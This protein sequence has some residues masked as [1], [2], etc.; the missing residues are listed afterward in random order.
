VFPNAEVNKALVNAL[1]TMMFIYSAMKI[2]AK[3]PPPYSTLKPETSSD[4][5][6][7]KSKGVR[8]VSA[9][10]EVN[11]QVKRGGTSRA[12][13]LNR[14]KIGEVKLYLM[15]RSKEANIRSA[16]LISYE[17]VCAIARIVPINAYFLL[18]VHPA[19]SRT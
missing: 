13:Q 11:Q 8:F 7:A 3:F 1:I 6:S 15:S 4:S 18:D 9:R 17:I 5:P 12:D 19:A 14:S 2:N 10:I 16:I